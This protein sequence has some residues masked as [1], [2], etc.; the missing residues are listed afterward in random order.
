[1]P[2]IEKIVQTAKQI[3]NE[4]VESQSARPWCTVLEPGVAMRI[5]REKRSGTQIAKTRRWLFALDQTARPESVTCLPRGNVPW[6]G[7]IEVVIDHLPAAGK[8]PA[9]H[10]Y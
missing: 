9:F 8:V 7:F 10:S 5:P 6:I 3:V 4:M 2:M 1:M